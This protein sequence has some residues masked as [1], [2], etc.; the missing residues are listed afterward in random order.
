VRRRPGRWLIALAA[1]AALALVIPSQAVPQGPTPDLPT[2]TPGQPSVTGAHSVDLSGSVNPEGLD[3]TAWFAYGLDPKYTGKAEVN[4]DNVTD[5]QDLGSD[6]SDHPLTASPTGLLPHALYHVELV[7]QNADGITVGPDQTFTTGQDPPPPPP[8]L[9]KSAD[10]KPVSGQIFV[11]LPSGHS[12]GA[13]AD[14][15]ARAGIAQAHGFAPLTE[16]QRLPA[17]TQIDARHGSLGLTTATGHD[18][19]DQTGT[20]GGGV[21]AFSQAKSGR[22]KG[23]TTLSLVEGA[24]RGGPTFASCRTHHHGPLG[25]AASLSPR[26]L[27]TLNAR[28]NHG[29][30][31]TRGRR[32]A[33][34][35]RGTKWKMSERCD[36]T[37]TSVQRGAVVVLIFRTHKTLVL[38]AGHSYLAH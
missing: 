27:Q 35:V 10:V 31:R 17:G 7:A 12:G 30:F 14:E 21:F 25:G 37:L 24:F 3:T 18:G 28:D 16:A 8:V 2:V 6:F 33:A 13:L 23:L 5:S 11:K 1:V 15:L 29:S 32:S 20:F 22:Q 9:G 36:G 19:K 38:S 26:I 4:Y 34:T